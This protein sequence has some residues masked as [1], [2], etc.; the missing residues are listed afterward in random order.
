MAGPAGKV[1]GLKSMRIPSGRIDKN[2]VP[3]RTYMKLCCLEMERFR[4][5]K[6]R[7]RSLLLVGEIDRRFREIEDEKAKLL[8][9]M[10]SCGKGGPSMAHWTEGGPAAAGRRRNG[11]RLKY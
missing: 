7:E 11:I 9:M 2:A 1:R 10:E 6:E 5:G 3:Y 4:R 8:Q